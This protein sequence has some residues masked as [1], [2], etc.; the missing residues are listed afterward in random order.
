MN[1]QNKIHWWEGLYLSPEH[2]QEEQNNLD[3]RVK[4]F[5]YIL[6]NYTTVNKLEINQLLLT[7]GI[8]QILAFEGMFP[9][10]DYIKYNSEEIFNNKDKIYSIKEDINKYNKIINENGGL[11]I[12]LTISHE[13]LYVTEE[14]NNVKIDKIIPKIIITNENSVED[15]N[16]S[17]PIIR[18]ININGNL[19]VD[20]EYV[21]PM[22]F[23]HTSNSFYKKIEEFIKFL[24]NTA[25]MTAGEFFTRV[26]NL[27]VESIFNKMNY[28]LKYN[29]L[30][31]EI[32]VLE[33]LL[34]NKG[35]PQNIFICLQRII[36]G[37]SLLRFTN[38]PS[39]QIYNHDNIYESLNTL[40]NII[41]IMLENLK[42]KGDSMIMKYTNEK[43]N[44]ELPLEV[45][46]PL[47]KTYLFIELNNEQEKNEAINWIEEAKIYGEG[48]EEVV[49][50]KRVSGLERKILNKVLFGN[51]VIVV[52]VNM[53]S[54]FVQM[55]NNILYI[56]NS[57][58]TYMPK[59]ILLSWRT[60]EI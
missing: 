3:N 12:Y 42:S 48:F 9:N 30:M 24:R 5:Q 40:M 26:N 29:S 31:P 28:F 34:L 8:I 10:M 15:F 57:I 50:L 37:L 59:N 7:R 39:L 4:N 41:K 35:H 44:L 23:F 20:D 54:E 27:D 2:L 56:Y 22:V 17:L 46:T 6:N 58:S 55:N 13:I 21:P 25:M 32:L 45:F 16:K 49:N 51:Q 47:I 53:N 18:I 60:E 36:G 14:I 33:S 1:I 19:V 38:L 52:E 11:L 43:F